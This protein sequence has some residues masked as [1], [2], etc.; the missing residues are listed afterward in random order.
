MNE[1]VKERYSPVDYEFSLA[2]LLIGSLTMPPDDSIHWEKQ[3]DPG[4]SSQETR[5][6]SVCR[7]SGPARVANCYPKL[8]SETALTQSANNE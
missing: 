1:R 8:H 4:Y 3:Q 5:Y 6:D 7:R 2:Y